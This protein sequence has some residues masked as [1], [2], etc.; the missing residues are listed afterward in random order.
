MRVAPICPP[1]PER[2]IELPETVDDAIYT[3]LLSLAARA[4]LRLLLARI[5]STISLAGVVA[6]SLSLW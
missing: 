6:I 5:G 2:L 3:H 4:P 1:G